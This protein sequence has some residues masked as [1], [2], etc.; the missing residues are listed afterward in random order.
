MTNREKKIVSL[1]EEGFSYET[2]KKMSD[3]HINMLYNRLVKEAAVYKVPSNKLKDVEKN[4]PPDATVEVTE[5]EDGEVEDINKYEVIE[6]LFGKPKKKMKTPISTLGMFEGEIGEKFVSKAQQGLFYAKCEEEGPKSKW[7]KMAK[8]FSDDTKDFKSL[9]KKVSKEEKIRHVEE[10]IL[11]LIRKNQGKVITKGDILQ[12][13]EPRTVPKTPTIKPGV[14]PE[15]STPYK[16]KHPTK[17]KAGTE[18]KPAEPK[19]MPD[20]K[21]ER[22]TPYKPKHPTKPKAGDEGGLPEFLK[23]NSLNIKFRDE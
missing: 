22:S 15:R 23:F 5:E 11:S 10:S 1:L 19:V 7:C 20:V 16:P 9:P 18:V 3:T 8:E 17:P 2:I 6:K 14:K 21:P 4:L 12:E 13:A